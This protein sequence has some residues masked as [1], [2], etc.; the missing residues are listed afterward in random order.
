[1]SAPSEPPY[2][3]QGNRDRRA[4]Y[5]QGLGGNVDNA[6]ISNLAG[7]MP[8]GDRHGAASQE[9]W[10]DQRHFYTANDVDPRMCRRWQE[11]GDLAANLPVAPVDDG[12]AGSYDHRTRSGNVSNEIYEHFDTDSEVESTRHPSKFNDR[13]GI[14]NFRSDGA[15]DQQADGGGTLG[16]WGP[17]SSSQSSLDDYDQSADPNA[18]SASS[19]RAKTVM[20]KHTCRTSSDNLQRE[21]GPSSAI[22]ET[23]EEHRRSFQS[24]I[25]DPTSMENGGWSGMDRSSFRHDD[26]KRSS[27]R[28]ADSFHSFGHESFG[29]FSKS[30]KQRSLNRPSWADEDPEDDVDFK[31]LDFAGGDDSTTN[32]FDA[33]AS[34]PRRYD[35]SL[36][37][38]SDPV[39]EKDTKQSLERVDI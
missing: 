26:A 3:Q 1:M 35:N 21:F 39:R 27:F 2:P 36:E 5:M 12:Y 38:E 34:G 24:S 29:S 9:S 11:H 8:P 17:R 4:D 22:A 32:T 30:S 33:A 25:A 16:E 23:E 15:A 6:D 7:Y 19:R 20:L 14:P 13:P 28:N 31:P 10:Q 37:R 18:G